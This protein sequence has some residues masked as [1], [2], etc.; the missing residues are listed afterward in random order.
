MVRIEFKRQVHK[1]AVDH[2][3]DRTLLARAYARGRMCIF[4]IDAAWVRV[5]GGELILAPSQ[6]LITRAEPFTPMSGKEFLEKASPLFSVPVDG[7]EQ[8]IADRREDGE[9][10]STPAELRLVPPTER[11]LSMH[12]AAPESDPPLPLH[13]TTRPC[14]GCGAEVFVPL[15]GE[16]VACP[17]CVPAP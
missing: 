17:V 1:I 10:E 7:A 13:G 14:G 2:G 4:W 11:D 9:P 5:R 15:G 12:D 8:I 6:C 3:V 16:F